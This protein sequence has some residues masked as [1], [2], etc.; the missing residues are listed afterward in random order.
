MHMDCLSPPNTRRFREI[1]EGRGSLPHLSL[2]FAVLAVGAQLEGFGILD[3]SFET[4]VT[5]SLLS[6][7]N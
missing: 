2:I 5:L 7:Y 3:D 4:G 1:R 6:R